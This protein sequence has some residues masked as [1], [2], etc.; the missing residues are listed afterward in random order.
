MSNEDKEIETIPVGP[1]GL[2]PLKSCEELGKKVDA[3][4]VRWRNARQSEHKD[5][6]A[7]MGYEKDSFIVQSQIN[8]FGTGEG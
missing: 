6:L 1:L 4:L 3:Y 8:R 5:T 2:V 7:F